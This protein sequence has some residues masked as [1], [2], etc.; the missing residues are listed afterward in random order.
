MLA[1]EH[2]RDLAYSCDDCVRLLDLVPAMAII[3]D[4]LAQAAHLTL[5]AV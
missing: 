3:L 1:N 5:D 4:H 2:Q